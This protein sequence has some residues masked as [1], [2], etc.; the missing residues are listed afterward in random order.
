MSKRLNFLHGLPIGLLPLVPRVVSGMA[1]RVGSCI[2]VFLVCCELD[3]VVVAFTFTHGPAERA[4]A[5]TS[6][7][8]LVETFAFP[9]IVFYL[10]FAFAF[11]KFAI[12]FA[13]V[14]ACFALPFAWAVPSRV[15]LMGAR[16]LCDMG[17]PIA[18]AAAIAHAC[19]YRCWRPTWTGLSVIL[20]ATLLAQ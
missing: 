6:R 4:F 8:A 1:P 17:E 10:A 19:S 18:V 2:T 7:F 14:F 15:A 16:P 20:I 9:I 5:F 3:L 12:I 11:A 13:V